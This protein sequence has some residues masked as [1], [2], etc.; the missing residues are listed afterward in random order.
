MEIIP[1]SQPH[2]PES[3][4]NTANSFDLLRLFFSLI[5]VV[6]HCFPTAG[7]DEKGIWLDASNK[8]F[9]SFGVFSVFAFFLISGYL[10]TASFENSSSITEYFKKRF[11]RIYPGLW[12]C[13]VV[14]AF[15]FGY[16]FH[17]IKTG[18]NYFEF[19]SVYLR[20][21]L[22]YIEGNLT[23][24]VR[25]NTINDLVSGAGRGDAYNS[26]L[27]TIIFEIRAYIFVAIF[28]FFG[29]FKRR[30]L[31]LA[32]TIG[33]WI[34]NIV[35]SYYGNIADLIG[36]W[37]GNSASTSL[38]TYFLVGMC[39]WLFRDKVK[40]NIWAFGISILVFIL[41]ILLKLYPFAGPISF[42]YIIFFFAFN[43]PLKSTLKKYGDPSYGIY[44]YS[45]PIQNVLFLSGFVTKYGMMAHIVMSLFLSTLVG[46]AS[47]HFVEKHFLKKKTPSKP[48]LL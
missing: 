4:S 29:F 2:N 44:I 9:I 16:I 33:M 15:F 40:Y 45:W 42:G 38:Y 17:Y 27:W 24:F 32:V 37:V 26:S 19:L 21:C 12:V 46:F 22:H 8:N 25:F 11:L 43:F 5:V 41:A 7:L 47:W 39:F 14:S 6:F 20:S 30:Y 10:I 18:E 23:G 3:S 35:S 31:I 34:T 48:L 13:F 1:N 28:G 36:Y